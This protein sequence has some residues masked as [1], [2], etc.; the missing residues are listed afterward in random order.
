LWK[1]SGRPKTVLSYIEAHLPSAASRFETGSGGNV[2]T[3]SSSQDVGYM[4][5]AAPG[6]LRAR[7]LEVTVTALPGGLTG[8]LAQSQSDWFVPR[9][10]SERVPPGVQ[11]IGLSVTTFGGGRVVS[12]TVRSATKIG[13]IVALI[14]AMPIVQPDTFS[15]PALILTGARVIEL[16]FRAAM[17]RL[18]AEASYTDYPSIGGVSGA[19]NPIAFTVHGRVQRPLIGGHFVDRLGRIVG[20][21]ALG[22]G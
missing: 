5:P 12:R 20:S 11:T 13:R 3:G 22:G 1:V 19:C 21:P 9:P 10:A 4:W 18:V 16:K 14:D 2:R 7:V 15:C 6:V 8:V 17:S